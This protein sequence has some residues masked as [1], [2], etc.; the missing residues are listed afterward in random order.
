M[1]LD[2]GAQS[3]LGLMLCRVVRNPSSLT[4]DNSLDRRRP[5]FQKR[6]KKRSPLKLPARRQRQAAVF[7]N[8]GR[9]RAGSSGKSDGDKPPSASLVVLSTLGSQSS[10]GSGLQCGH[11]SNL[12]AALQVGQ[13]MRH[14]AR[15]CAY[16]WR[17]L[18]PTLPALD[19]AA[20]RNTRIRLLC[21]GQTH[22]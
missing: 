18:R 8:A 21:K 5:M 13:V 14:P 6:R 15:L 22:R 10:I 16:S 20:N 2:P 7:Q 11:G 19:S 12:T 1:R 3:R 9:G 4:A 17:Q